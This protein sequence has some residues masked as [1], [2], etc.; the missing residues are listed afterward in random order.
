MNEEKNKVSGLFS[1]VKIFQKLKGIKHIEI[2]FA[3][4][5]CAIIVVIYLSSLGKNDNR[6]TSS[7]NFTSISE[8]SAFLE[9]KLANVLGNIDG[10]GNVSAMITFESGTEYVYAQ[11]EESKTNSNTSASSTTSTTTTTSSPY[12][13]NNEGLLI[14]EILPKI[15]GVVVV[16]SGAKDTKVKLEIVK[17][18]QALLDV[19]IAN[20]EVL[21]G[22]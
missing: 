6:Q 13:K 9:N 12:I 8:Y 16:C 14:K 1:N 11:N 18:V 21:V 7:Q 5:L 19:P 17:A 3:I 10:A 22:K 15:S 2:I 20:I 4:I